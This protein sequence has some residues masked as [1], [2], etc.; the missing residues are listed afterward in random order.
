[1][2]AGAM[3]A[4]LISKEDYP[5][6]GARRRGHTLVCHGDDSRDPWIDSLEP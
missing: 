5:E 3:S 2:G 4:N 6:V 1:M